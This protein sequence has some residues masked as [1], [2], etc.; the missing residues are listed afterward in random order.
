MTLTELLIFLLIGLIAGWIGSKVV[1][2]ASSGMLTNIVVGIIGAFLGGWLFGVLG[3]Y[4]G[5]G[6]LGSIITASVGA[7]VLLAI[8]R[9][10]R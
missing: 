8:L 7:I 1:R 2:G 5:S 10:V 4:A 9:A 6:L 3:I